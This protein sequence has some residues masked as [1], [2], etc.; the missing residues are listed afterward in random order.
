MNYCSKNFSISFAI[1]LLLIACY[2]HEVRADDGGNSDKK[3][4]LKVHIPNI[5][6]QSKSVAVVEL[7]ANHVDYSPETSMISASGDV[8]IEAGEKII[9]GDKVV[10]GQV[11]NSLIVSGNISI[12]E[13]N[14]QVEF[15]NDEYMSLN[16]NLKNRIVDLLKSKI[17]HSQPNPMDFAAL[18]PAAGGDQIIPTPATPTTQV[19]PVIGNVPL[20]SL[21]EVS[22]LD[23]KIPDTKSTNVKNDPQKIE[24]TAPVVPAVIAAPTA[25][26]VSIATTDI[27]APDKKANDIVDI[28]KIIPLSDNKIDDKISKSAAELPDIHADMPVEEP[29]KKPVEKPIKKI[30]KKHP[31]IVEPVKKDDGAEQAEGLSPDSQKILDKITP[32]IPQDLAPKP[33][34]VSA[35]VEVSREH[36]MQNLFKNDGAD[37]ANPI[38]NQALANQAIKIEHKK[39]PINTDYELEKAYDA[40]NSGQS[41]TA[42]EIYKNVL[43]NNPNNTQALFGL[44]TM[45]HRA[46][47]L[48]K[49]RPLYAKLLAI[50]PQNRDGFNNFLVLLADEAPRE[51]LV[52]LEKLETKNPSFGTIPAQM[53]VIYQKLG[54]MDKATDKMFRA[55]SL[56]PENLTYRYNLA[57]MMDKQHNYEEAEKLYKQL[58]E[59][60]ERGEKIPGNLDTLKQRLTFISSNR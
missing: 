20:I 18:A 31:K 2:A 55:V 17:A 40:T 16:G 59:A 15:A 45:Y 6:E 14:G 43:E 39:Q 42:I 52:E 49:A 46:R 4:P 5:S 30:V 25:P 48:D 60:A 38:P 34:K 11:D 12:L 51:A 8:E 10:Y 36:E 28:K 44:A 54:D 53:A 56:A 29:V 26:T 57:I 47:Q 13:P 41:A 35:P 50:D 3:Q 1:C 24:P 23:A 9:H 22:L 27:P 7:N 37:A 21:P 58:V 33:D 32:K 19:A